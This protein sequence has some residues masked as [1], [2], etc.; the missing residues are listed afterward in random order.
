MAAHDSEKQ[1]DAGI[2]SDQG[3]TSSSTRP[4]VSTMKIAVM[5]P[6]SAKMEKM[7]NT[8]LIP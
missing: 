6:V 3:D 5:P 1:N 8:P 2:S 7:R 4:P